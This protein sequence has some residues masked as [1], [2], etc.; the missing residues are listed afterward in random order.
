VREIELINAMPIAAERGWNVAEVHDKRSG[1][2]DSIRLEVETDS[3]VTTVEGAV[4]LGKPLACPVFS[5]PVLMRETGLKRSG[6][7]HEG[8]SIQRSR[9]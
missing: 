6:T 2:M 9:L 5:V 8:R 3:S 1:H 7:W 4:V